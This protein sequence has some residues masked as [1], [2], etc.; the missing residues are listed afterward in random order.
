[1]FK[2]SKVTTEAGELINAD[3]RTGI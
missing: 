1:M 2:D 3:L